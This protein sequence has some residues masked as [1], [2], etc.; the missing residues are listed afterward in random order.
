MNGQ[1]PH[2][3]QAASTHRRSTRRTSSYGSATVQP[4][5]SVQHHRV[6]SQSRQPSNGENNARSMPPPQSAPPAAPLMRTEGI[7]PPMTPVPPVDLSPAG[8][9]PVVHHRAVYGPAHTSVNGVVNGHDL[10]LPP[11]HVAHSYALSPSP[12]VLTPAT[13][14]Q[15]PG[16]LVTQGTVVNYN[17]HSAP[18]QTPIYFFQASSADTPYSAHGQAPYVMPMAQAPAPQAQTCLGDCGDPACQLPPPP[19]AMYMPAQP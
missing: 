7:L 18:P 17:P 16:H 13:H 8:S 3:G 1:P 12:H 14:I 5:H 10:H 6:P 11:P 9:V 15:Q 4:S 19:G 2:G